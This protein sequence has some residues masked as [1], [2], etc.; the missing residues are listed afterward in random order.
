MLQVALAA[1]IPF[2]KWL[3]TCA[4]LCELRVMAN[5]LM[6]QEKYGFSS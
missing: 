2:S 1:F 4:L 5:Q 6:L 3:I